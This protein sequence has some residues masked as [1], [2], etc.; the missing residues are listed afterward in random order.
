VTA[1]QGAKSLAQYRN[2]GAQAGQLKGDVQQ[3]IKTQ[4]QEDAAVAAAAQQLISQNG[5]NI[6]ALR[7]IAQ[8]GITAGRNDASLAGYLNYGKQFKGD[9]NQLSLQSA[10]LERWAPLAGSADVNQVAQVAAAAQRYGGQI[11]QAVFSTLPAQFVLVS[12]S[13]QHVWAYQNGQVTMDSAVTT[14]IQGVTDFGTDFGPMK[15]LYKAHPWTMKSPYPKG[16]QYWYPDTP[17]QWTVWFTMGESFHDASWES[18]SQLGPGSQYDPS[19]RS[20]G[21]IHLPLNL[22]QWIYDWAN[23]GTPVIVYPGDG[24]PPAHQLSQI[25]TDPAGHPNNPA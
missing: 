7:Q 17:V 23:V 12:F 9:Y 18:D 4:Q 8:S 5:G 15:V 11:H 13:G 2:V 1:Q 16:S 14:G 22:A 20:H 6:D 24:T 19:T 25:T 3:L 10:R 21:C